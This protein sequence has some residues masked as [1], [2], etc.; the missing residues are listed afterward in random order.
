MQRFT[1]VAVRSV[2]RI[3]SSHAGFISR[4]TDVVGIFPNDQA[5]IRLAG[6]AQIRAERRVVSRVPLPSVES[7]ALIIAAEQQSEDEGE[8]ERRRRAL[9][10]Y[11]RPARSAMQRP[12]IRRPPC[13][14]DSEN[15]ETQDDRLIH[16]GSPPRLLLLRRLGIDGDK[17]KRCLTR[18][19]LG[20]PNRH[21]GDR[22]VVGAREPNHRPHRL[23][24]FLEAL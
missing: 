5:V 7:M 20:S 1:F 19:S 22:V 18:V 15:R 21:L 13:H 14:R 3:P 17:Y 10:K 6:A 2:R 4:R 23:L 24:T 11:R 16:R 12:G 8:L 9:R